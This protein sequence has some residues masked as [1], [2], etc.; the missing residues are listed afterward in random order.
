MDM[1]S[2]TFDLMMYIICIEKESN[3]S[4]LWFC[5]TS[6]VYDSMEHS[7]SG[8]AKRGSFEKQICGTLCLVFAAVLCSECTALGIV[9]SKYDTSFPVVLIELVSALRKKNVFIFQDR[10]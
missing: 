3:Y 7:F 10:I 4:W 6:I 9:L 1:I 8:V 5:F 2:P